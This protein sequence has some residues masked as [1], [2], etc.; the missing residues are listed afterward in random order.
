MKSVEEKM[1]AAI[2][3]NKSAKFG[4]TKVVQ[5]KDSSNVYFYGSL[6]AA[7][8]EKTV[9]INNCGRLTASTKSRLNAILSKFTDNRQIYQKSGDWYLSG[10]PVNSLDCGLPNNE[11]V[12]LKNTFKFNSFINK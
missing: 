9:K 7:I 10:E 1:I 12:E 5:E 3:T 11:W 2:T 8:T 6:I 4:T